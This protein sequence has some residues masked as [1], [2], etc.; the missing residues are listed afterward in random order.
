MLEG[1]SDVSNLLREELEEP[2][3]WF[4]EPGVSIELLSLNDELPDFHSKH[5]GL[6]AYV[7]KRSLRRGPWKSIEDFKA[8]LSAIQPTP[9][10][11]CVVHLKNEKDV[12]EPSFPGMDELA[13]LETPGGELLT[14]E[15]K[16]HG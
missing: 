5:C 4:T 8:E 6:E 12:E 10:Q 16:S 14:V 7:N 11:S 13:L 3:E 9:D 15:E 2:E 1:E